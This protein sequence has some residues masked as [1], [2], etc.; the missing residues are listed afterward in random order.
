MSAFFRVLILCSG[1]IAC[2][3]CDSSRPAAPSPRPTPTRTTPP[4]APVLQI[5]GTCEPDFPTCVI[6]VG[7]QAAFSA[8]A[9]NGGSQQPQATTWTSNDPAVASVDADGRVRGISIGS[10]H[11]RAIAG[12]LTGTKHVQ[13]V[14]RRVGTWKGEFVIR[15]CR[16]TNT[17]VFANCREFLAV[18]S[19]W[20]F[21]VHLIEKDGR[22]G[23]SV[24]ID[25]SGGGLTIDDNASL[26]RDGT[27]RLSARGELGLGE[28]DVV[29]DPLRARIRG[30]TLEGSFRMTMTNAPFHVV[31]WTTTIEADL[32]GMTREGR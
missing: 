25:R 9:V 4:A 29:I 8:V 26:D 23:G 12:S 31:N 14:A 21:E 16:D 5:D 3:G 6:Q 7:S 2:A 32:A 17:D 10:T 20:L 1:V 22:L 30:N 19:R 24:I 18:G 15:T 13:V 28:A 11:I 27:L